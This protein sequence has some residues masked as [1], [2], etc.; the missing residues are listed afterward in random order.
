MPV[1]S[2]TIK[3]H[4]TLHVKRQCW[5]LVT[6]QV[7]N[8]EALGIRW[9]AYLKRKFISQEA[10]II[11]LTRIVRK[12]LKQQSPMAGCALDFTCAATLSPSS[13][14]P[15]SPAESEGTP[16]SSEEDSPSVD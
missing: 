16:K 9:P 3:V 10:T 1:I 7:E 12:C 15:V 2:R 6:C 4:L 13:G 11:Y 5:Y 14:S 8:G